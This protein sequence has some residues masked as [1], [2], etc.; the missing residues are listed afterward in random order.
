MDLLGDREVAQGWLLKPLRGHNNQSPCCLINTRAGYDAV[1]T[2]LK[3][4]QH[5]ML[6]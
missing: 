3:R 2:L 1:S 6:C 5:G 4:L